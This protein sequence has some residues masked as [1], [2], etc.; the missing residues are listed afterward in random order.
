MA[1]NKA[2]EIT[3]LTRQR[4]Y[5][6]SGNQCAFPNCSQTFFNVDDETNI[7]NICHIEAAEPGGQRYNPNSNDE[8]RRC[9]ENL[10]LLCPNHHKVTDNTQAYTIEVLKEMKRNH[11]AKFI[12]IATGKN[13]ITQ[14]PSALNVVIGSLGSTIFDSQNGNEPMSA[15]DP[16]DKIKYNNIIRF[17]PIIEEYK[18]YQG[19]LNKIYEEIEKQ[20]STRKEFILH[21]IKSAYLLEKG[22][23]DNIDQIRA[24]AD[25][26]VE[27]VQAKL[28]SIIENSSNVNPH[29]PIEAVQISLYVVLVDAFMRCSILEEPPKQ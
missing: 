7:S 23:Y 20:G 2:R 29:L 25:N 4:L 28:W 1:K 27:N 3:Q 14:N 5:A 17:K 12:Q 11:E 8:Y 19:R 15:P 9:F 6:M 21:N 22:K 26:I 13:I 24:N 16:E 10:I 18:V